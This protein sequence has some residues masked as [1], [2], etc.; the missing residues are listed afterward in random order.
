[1]SLVIGSPR[2]GV[3]PITNAFFV[4]CQGVRS[5]GKHGQMLVE[6]VRH[7]FCIVL[8]GIWDFQIWQLRFLYFALLS[9]WIGPGFLTVL[10][11]AWVSFLDVIHALIVFD[12][13]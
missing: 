9:L 5:G 2:P 12:F 3:V 4:E 10:L 13:D 6:L 1:M 8:V 11:N 7:M